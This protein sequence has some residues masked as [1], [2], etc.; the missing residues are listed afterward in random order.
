MMNARRI[1]RKD[2]RG[3]ASIEFALIA[4][5]LAFAFLN[6]CD[7]AVYLFDGMQVNNA[8]Q[9]GAQAAFA[10]CDLN[11]LPA[12]TNCSGLSSAVT[13]AVG[14]TSLGSAVSER[15]GSPS[16]AYY[17][18]TSGGALQNVG[19]VSSAK[20][21]DCSAAGEPSMKPGDYVLIQTTYTFTPLF[22]G[23]SVGSLLPAT[24]TDSAEVRLG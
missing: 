1:L 20:P 2:E 5:F 24:I 23:A 9:M 13:A 19:S 21:A 8:T 4:S 22:P 15:S 16:E 11:H 10:A 17:C 14:S 18:P 12:T 6:V 7:V 3:I